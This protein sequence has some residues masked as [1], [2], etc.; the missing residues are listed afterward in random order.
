MYQGF[1][2]F[3]M[4]QSKK[5]LNWLTK[6]I[7]KRWKRWRGSC[8]WFMEFLQKP[9]YKNIACLLSYNFLCF[10]IIFFGPPLWLWS[11]TRNPLG[12]WGWNS[13]VYI[14]PTNCVVYYRNLFWTKWTYMDYFNPLFLL[15]VLSKVSNIFLL[16]NMNLLF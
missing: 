6:Y 10:A 13:F 8:I 16:I 14:S 4:F 15:L 2:A 9:F 1:S 7:T 3:S 11:F 5:K 12:F